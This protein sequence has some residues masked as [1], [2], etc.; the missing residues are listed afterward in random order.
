M[1]MN[2]EYIEGVDFLSV[3]DDQIL[4]ALFGETVTLPQRTPTENAPVSYVYTLTFNGKSFVLSYF[5]GVLTC[6][7]S[8]LRMFRLF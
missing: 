5:L 6:D 1:S 8:N 2:I 7:E 4:A 3:T